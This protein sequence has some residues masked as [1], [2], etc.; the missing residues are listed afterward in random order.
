MGKRAAVLASAVAVLA[1]TVSLIAPAASDQRYDRVNFTVRD[2]ASDDEQNN[3]DIDVGEQGFGVG[4]YFVLSKDPFFDRSLGKRLGYFTGDC[5]FVSVNEATFE[6]TI[7]CDVTVNFRNGS[8]ITVEGPVTFTENAEAQTTFAVTGGTGR[9]ETAH[10][11]VQ[12]TFAEEGGT[13]R[14]RLLV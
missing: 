9:Y 8:T 5:L 10:G 2:K 1:L 7:E 13:F 6:A 14:F 3:I 11:E 12:A 4:D